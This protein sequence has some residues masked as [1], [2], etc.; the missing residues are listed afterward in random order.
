LLWT[1][2][3]AAD[4]LVSGLLHGVIDKAVLGEMLANAG[5]SLRTDAPAKV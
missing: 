4:M 3:M 5:V 1:P 2:Q